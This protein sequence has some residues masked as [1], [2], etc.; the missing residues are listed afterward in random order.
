MAISNINNSNEALKFLEERIKSDDYRGIHLFQHYRYDIKFIKI[1][2]LELYFYEKNTNNKYLKIR[3]TDSSKRPENNADEVDYS[4]IVNNIK[5]KT[6]KGTQDAIRKIIF[7]DCNRMGFLNRYDKNKNLIPPNTNSK[8]YSF[9]SI[10]EKGKKFLGAKNLK[11]EYFIFSAGL[12]K[13]VGTLINILENLISKYDLKFISK[14]ECMYFVSAVDDNSS[15]SIDIDKCSHLIQQF[16]LLGDIDRKNVTKLLK[17]EMN[18]KNYQGNK[19]KKRDFAN[20]ENEASQIFLLLATT[21]YFEI[22]NGVKLMLNN[23][24]TSLESIIGKKFK[25]Q[26]SLQEKKNYYLNHEIKDKTL[27]F[28]L[29]HVVAL[30]YAD[31]PALYKLLDDWENMVYIDAFSHAKITQNKNR[32][33]VF[34]TVKDDIT[35]TDYSNNEVYLRHNENIL[36]KS[37]NKGTM[38]NYNKDLLN[39]IK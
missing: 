12:Y 9:V 4:N 7:V 14:Y 25:K 11:E 33:V 29:H 8:G 37:I 28:E 27:G 1:V 31:S 22:R 23:S 36:Y 3:T 6:G 19:K 16:R 5:T 34:E 10:S 13:I 26:R 15:F 39:T 38:K 21:V 32:N 20:W 24:D 35:L 17:K 18:P 30:E 2:L